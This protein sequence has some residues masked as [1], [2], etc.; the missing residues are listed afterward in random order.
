ML[1]KKFLIIIMLPETNSYIRVKKI[2][3]LFRVIIYR[4]IYIYN[5]RHTPVDNLDAWIN[6]EFVRHW[7]V[8]NTNPLNDSFVKLLLML[9]DSRL[10]NPV[11]LNMLTSFQPALST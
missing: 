5:S 4:Y 8:V 7:L 11:Y 9:N 1:E 2:E 10:T 6:S 3:R